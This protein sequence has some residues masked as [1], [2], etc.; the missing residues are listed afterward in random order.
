MG[1]SNHFF[2]N[3]LNF[4]MFADNDDVKIEFKKKKNAYIRS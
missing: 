4:H 2:A 1:K 3:G